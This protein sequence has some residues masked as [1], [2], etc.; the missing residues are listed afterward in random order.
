M[1]PLFA[2]HNNVSLL[3]VTIAPSAFLAT[4][5][6]V[7]VFLSLY[8]PRLPSLPRLFSFGRRRTGNTGEKDVVLQRHQRMPRDFGD[9]Y[10]NFTNVQQWRNREDLTIDWRHRQLPPLPPPPFRPLL[11]ERGYVEASEYLEEEEDITS[12]RKKSSSRRSSQQQK[13]HVAA[14]SHFAKSRGSIEPPPARGRI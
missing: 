10:D 7:F 1:Q 8:L 11:R 3:S 6:L 9:G 12:S 4:L 5:T 14:Y 2:V 13:V